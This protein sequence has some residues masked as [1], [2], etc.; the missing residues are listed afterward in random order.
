MDLKR[1]ILF[2]L[3]NKLSNS[4]DFKIK[5]IRREIALRLKKDGK[6]GFSI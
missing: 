2:I 4:N 1:K 3:L 6:Y 5:E